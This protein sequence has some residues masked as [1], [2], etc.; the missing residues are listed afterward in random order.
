MKYLVDRVLVSPGDDRWAI[1]AKI[2]SFMDVS[3]QSIRYEII[4]RKL[5]FSSNGPQEEIRA[6]VDTAA[7]VRNTGIGFYSPIEPLSIPKAKK[8]D[9]PLVVGGGMAGLFAALALAEAGARPILF[10]QGGK[11]VERQEAVESLESLFTF[12]PENNYACGLGGYSGYCGG[13]LDTENL[14]PCSRYILDELKEQGVVPSLRHDFLTP[15]SSLQMRGAVQ[16]ICRKILSLGGEIHPHAKLVGFTHFFGRC[17]GV[18]VQEGGEKK[19]YSGKRALLMTGPLQESLLPVLKEAKIHVQGQD[20]YFGFLLEQR[21]RPLQAALFGKSSARMI[22][23]PFASYSDGFILPSKRSVYLGY[24]YPHA[25]PC[26]VS[27]RNDFSLL[28]G[29]F[30][31]PKQENS[32]I[33]LLLKFSPSEKDPS[34]GEG[35]IQL[36]KN[37]L[38][39][40]YRPGSPFLAPCEKLDDFLAGREPYRLGLT[41]SSY[42]PGVYLADLWKHVPA[43][44]KQ[45]FTDAFH[46]YGSDFPG[47]RANGL[48]VLGFTMART[49]PYAI[50]VDE[51]GRTSFRGV[52]AA[53]PPSCAKEDIL[54]EASRGVH[55][56]LNLLE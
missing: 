4:G 46:H 44:W 26:N 49:S 22:D 10:E 1:R 7:F 13:I 25:Q 8:K 34:S 12:D 20:F 36:L 3:E 45:D 9:R 35:A 24:A 6:I 43:L 40:S 48:L 18:V 19:T 28:M 5:I 56:A 33:S 16:G 32:V 17:S 29:A 53:L 27:S 2:A 30:P 42:R 47:V 39:G 54:Q 11:G 14:D 52:S 37:A 15:V 41:K 38:S 55:A 31:E 51:Q 21:A 50:Q 23:L